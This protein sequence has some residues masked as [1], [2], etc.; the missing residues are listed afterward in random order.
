MMDEARQVQKM[1]VT[2]IELRTQSKDRKERLIKREI[3]S[4]AKGFG[5]TF[6]RSFTET[7]ASPC[8][9]DEDGK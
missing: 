3:T 1:D 7:V 6:T 5:I 8:D 4:K 9:E 2:S